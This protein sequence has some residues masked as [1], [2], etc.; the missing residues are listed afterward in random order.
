M[1][2]QRLRMLLLRDAFDIQLGGREGRNRQTFDH[3]E[4]FPPRRDLGA[5]LS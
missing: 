5:D 4:T 2:F 1:Y 3:V